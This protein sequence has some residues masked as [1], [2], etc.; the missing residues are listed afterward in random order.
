LRKN[1]SSFSIFQIIL[2]FILIHDAKL[3][4]FPIPANTL[5]MVFSADRFYPMLTL[6][7]IGKNRPNKLIIIYEY[8][9]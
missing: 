6:S 2:V 1:T 8:I 9:G 4:V 3:G 5:K 7:Q